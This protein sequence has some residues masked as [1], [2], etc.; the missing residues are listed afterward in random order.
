MIA[1]VLGIKPS[2]SEKEIKISYFKLAKKYHPDMNPD[3]SAKQQFEK[4]SKAYE[5][6]MDEA[7]RK[8]YDE[9]QGFS[10]PEA[11]F[12]DFHSHR[13]RKRNSK[14]F[15]DDEKEDDEYYDLYSRRGDK[16]TMPGRD[17]RQA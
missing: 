4:V 10:R 17:W 9:Q 1:E 14:I 13:S 11:Q 7:Q 12:K 3:Q 16:R 8:Q 6:L 5:V 2:A 15:S